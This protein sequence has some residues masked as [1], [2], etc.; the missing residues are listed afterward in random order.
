[1]WCARFYDIE[2]RWNSVPR[3]RDKFPRVSSPNTCRWQ[4]HRHAFCLVDYNG[5]ASRRHWLMIKMQRRQRRLV[6]ISSA[7]SVK[8]FE[9]ILCLIRRDYSRVGDYYILLWLNDDHNRIHIRYMLQMWM[10]LYLDQCICGRIKTPTLMV[11]S[12]QN[13]L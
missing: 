11:Q 5:S 8:L 6:D 7:F 4:R 12:K 9:I 13:N 2:H 1:M 10:L 3:N